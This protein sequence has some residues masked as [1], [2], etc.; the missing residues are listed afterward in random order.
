MW[1]IAKRLA[2]LAEGRLKRERTGFETFDPMTDRHGAYQ[3]LF[4]RLARSSWRYDE[5][6]CS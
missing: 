6:S 2:E 4:R 3:I 1:E 5:Q